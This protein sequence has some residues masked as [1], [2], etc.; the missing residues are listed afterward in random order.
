[1]ITMDLKNIFL[2]VR[3]I[4]ISNFYSYPFLKRKELIQVRIVILNYS[5]REC[6]EKIYC[7]RKKLLLA[8]F[9]IVMAKMI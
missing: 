1:M 5:Y 7:L 8:Y 6:S 3:Y 9:Y 2:Y 4:N